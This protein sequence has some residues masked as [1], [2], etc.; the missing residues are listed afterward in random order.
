MTIYESFTSGKEVRRR[1]GEKI[2]AMVLVDWAQRAHPI[3][4]VDESGEMSTHS[5]EGVYDLHN[6]ETE[7]DLIIH[8][9]DPR[10]EV[11]KAAEAWGAEMNKR[12]SEIPDLL[13]SGY[14][15]GLLT[16]IENYRK[17]K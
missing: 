2:M 10:D 8:Q 7:Y 1:S 16:A 9:P 3:I 15:T 14:A 12:I 11:I 17:S 5:L 6:S 13:V 4:A